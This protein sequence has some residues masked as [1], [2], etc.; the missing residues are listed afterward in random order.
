[1]RAVIRIPKGFLDSL[2][3]DLVRPHPLATERVGFIFTKTALAGPGQ[4]IVLPTSY[5]PV[6]DEHYLDDPTVA[7]R[8]G[9]DAI[10]LA[11]QRSRDTGHGCL[12]V[13]MHPGV[14]RPW[15]SRVDLATLH[16][17]S[18]SLRRMAPK[19]T[20]GGVV[21]AGSRAS[22]LVWTPGE[23]GPSE[24]DVSIVGFPMRLERSCHR[25]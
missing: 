2:V 3:E 10:R 4:A 1:M 5:A 9:S 15:F 8:I 6:E 23:A 14:S 11:H 22:A 24:A 7:V 21:L 19:A 20:H 16:G 13:H 18:P 17:L 25:G 12:H